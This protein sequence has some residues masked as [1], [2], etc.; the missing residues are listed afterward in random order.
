MS[1]TSTL[2]RPQT[3][4]PNLPRFSLETAQDVPEHGKEHRSFF[5][6]LSQGRAKLTYCVFSAVLAACLYLLLFAQPVFEARAQLKLALAPDDTFQEVEQRAG[7]SGRKIEIESQLALVMSKPVLESAAAHL[8]SNKHLPQADTQ[9]LASQVSARILPGSLILEI[10]AQGPTA[11]LAQAIC[12]AMAEAYLAVQVRRK[13]NETQQAI[14]LL[15]DK[16]K[17][18]TKEITRA[19][20]DLTAFSNSTE[21]LPDPHF[22]GLL[23]RLKN[24]QIRHDRMTSQPMSAREKQQAAA[25]AFAIDKLSLRIA[26]HGKHRA[27][28]RS[29]QTELETLRTVHKATQ[30]QLRTLTSLLGTEKPDADI[31]SPAKTP[32]RPILPRRGLTVSLFAIL[33][34]IVGMLWCLKSGLSRGGLRVPDHLAQMT[35]VPVLATLPEADAPLL[36]TLLGPPKSSFKAA[37]SSIAQAVLN[38][39]KNPKI[40]ALVAPRPDDGATQAALG[41]ADALAAEQR[42]LVVDCNMHQPELIHDFGEIPPAYGL[43]ALLMGLADQDQTIL[44][45]EDINLDLVAG[46]PVD[47]D[48]ATLL[49]STEFAEF[50]TQA[51]QQYQ[52]V[53]LLLPPLLACE[54]ALLILGKCDATFFCA[55]WNHTTAQDV[56]ECLRLMNATGHGLNGSIFTRK[57]ADPTAPQFTGYVRWPRPLGPELNPQ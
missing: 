42:V 26:Q 13:S 57:K 46:E 47:G 53:I 24:L 56:T 16:Q 38:D 55:R 51:K 14:R 34:L 3:Q 43:A 5:S 45:N 20:A 18:Q 11:E 9:A 39:P 29:M 44:R 1:G 15:Q 7:I 50:L 35:S 12:N 10:S 17:V 27:T 54:D 49:R 37:S 32:A 22:D 33:G 4:T 48:P 30:S 23:K 31:I 21:V 40:I 52:K 25:I 8:R 19:T 41:F 28:Q 36:N 2:T 6:L